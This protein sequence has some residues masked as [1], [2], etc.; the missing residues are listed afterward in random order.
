MIITYHNIEFFKVQFGD[1]VIAFNPISKDSK[2]KGPRFGADIAI[3]TANSV[4]LNGVESVSSKNKEP[5]VISGPGEYE[6]KG[7]FIRGVFYNTQYKGKSRINTV[8]SLTLDGI[9]IGFL[10]AL[11]SIELGENAKSVLGD[12]EVLFTPIGG[13][14]VLNASDAHKLATK[15]GA[16]IIIPM[17]YGDVGE[18]DA[19]KK[20]LKEGGEENVKPV[21]KLT[22]KKK[23]LEGR[24]GEI[25]VLNSEV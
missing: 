19:L 10:G 20:F 17:H 22:I 18:K 13:D 16:K 12:V 14:G 6:I 7:I 4:D 24:D 9:K 15:L 11:D 3:I 23:D 2:F 5:F 1:I 8:Y 21:D 25:I